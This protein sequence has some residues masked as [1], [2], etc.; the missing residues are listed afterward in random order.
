LAFYIY[1]ERIFIKL[2]GF[3]LFSDIAF[4]LNDLDYISVKTMGNMSN[5]CKKKGNKMRVT[6]MKVNLDNFL[7]FEVKYGDQAKSKI[8]SF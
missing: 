2:F 3:K 6:Q 1:L 8:H 5:Y 7:N 4:P